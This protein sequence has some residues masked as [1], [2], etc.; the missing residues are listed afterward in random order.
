MTGVFSETGYGGVY[1]GPF[2]TADKQRRYLRERGVEIDP[3]LDQNIRTVTEQCTRELVELQGEGRDAFDEKVQQCDQWLSDVTRAHLSIPQT[4][5]LGDI[6]YMDVLGLRV[7]D[8]DWLA[9]VTETPK[10]VKDAYELCVENP[11]CR[12]DLRGV[13]GK[14]IKTYIQYRMFSRATT[15][16]TRVVKESGLR[17]GLALDVRAAYYL[18]KALQNIA[19]TGAD[20]WNAY[21]SRK[22]APL[23]D[24]ESYRA[25]R[26]WE[27]YEDDTM[28]Y[29]RRTGQWYPAQRRNNYSRG[30]GYRRY[31]ST[32]YS[33]GYAPRRRRTYRRW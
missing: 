3:A 24:F 29:N 31:G 25:P 7:P 5:E 17:W 2:S 4:M 6:D 15:I 18:Q 11:A 13:V 27:G 10:V 16:L 20:I 14:V 30:G 8:A 23:E 28:P 21:Q 9:Y 26:E 19:F 32:R 12:I 33:G 1:Y 22:G